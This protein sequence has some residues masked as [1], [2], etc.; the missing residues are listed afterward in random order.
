MT[1]EVAEFYDTRRLAEFYDTRSL[2]EFYDTR[3]LA[4][5]YDSRSLAESN[6][7]SYLKWYYRYKIVIIISNYINNH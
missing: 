4:E 2:A 1:L 3:S 7:K 5:F 6:A